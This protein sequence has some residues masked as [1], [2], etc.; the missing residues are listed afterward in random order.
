MK[1]LV[2]IVLSILAFSAFAQDS[3]LPPPNDSSG[4]G[5]ENDDIIGGPKS[6]GGQLAAQNNSY[7]FEYRYKIKHFKEYFDWKDSLNKKTGIKF[8]INYTSVY[9]HSSDVISDNNVPNA[10]S[11]I[12][13]MQLGIN[14]VGRKSQKN[15]GT[16]FFKMNSRHNYGGKD[17]TSPM[18]H[19]LNESGY[20]GLPATAFRRYTLRVLELNWQQNLFNNRAA[21]VVGKVDMTNYFNFH[22]LVIPWQHF[23]GY[24]AS[25]SGTVNWGNQGL[26]GV[27]SVRPTENTYIMAGL[28]DVYGDRYEDGK[29]FD[30]GQEFQ[31]GKF[32]YMGEIGYVPTFAE[33][34]F[35][36]ISLTYWHSDSYTNPYGNFIGVGQG[37][38]FSSHWFFNNRFAPYL[39]FG[40]SNGVGENTFYKTDIQIGHGLRFRHYDMLGT[41]VSWNNPN[42]D[43]VKDQYTAE[44]FYRYNLHAHLEFTPSVQMI[45]NPTLNPN[46][47]T[48]FY[49]GLRGRILL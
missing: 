44:I 16:L 14:L 21:F 45:V 4:R 35:K 39:R 49:F 30:A 7:V 47:N 43:G 31:D 22:G 2:I 8:G 48:L 17:A 33:R 41:A 25:L 40:V 46:T 24:G 12:L 10:G 13:D 3:A 28:V 5:Y 6:I 37:L 42:I 1:Q 26:G 18:F 27:V 38:A 11:G 20:L 29:F 23:L 36:K 34:Y 15:K 9:I 19:G 32:M